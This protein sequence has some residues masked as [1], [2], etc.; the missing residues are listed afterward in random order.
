MDTYPRKLFAPNYRMTAAAVKAHLHLAAA[1][2]TEVAVVP[3]RRAVRVFRGEFV[4][5]GVSRDDPLPVALENFQR[6]VLKEKNEY[7]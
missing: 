2:G 4:E 6:L 5:G 3:R 1:E 7:L